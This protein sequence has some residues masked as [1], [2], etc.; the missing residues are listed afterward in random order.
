MLVAGLGKENGFCGPVD[1]RVLQQVKFVSFPF[2][3]D[4][5]NV[6]TNLQMPFFPRKSRS[7]HTCI[8][9]SKAIKVMRTFFFKREK[10]D[11]N[12]KSPCPARRGCNPQ[13]THRRL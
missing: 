7:F 6:I 12:S 10:A 13:S 1:A 3:L 4:A 2:S 11:E 5:S 9:W 8:L